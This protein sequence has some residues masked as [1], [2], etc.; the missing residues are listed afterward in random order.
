[1]V[2]EG[3]LDGFVGIFFGGNDHEEV[4]FMAKDGGGDGG[5]G[6]KFGE[7]FSAPVG[8]EGYFFGEGVMWEGYGLDGVFGFLLGVFAFKDDEEDFWVFLGEGLPG[9]V[10][11]ELE[12]MGVGVRG[13]LAWDF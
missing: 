8:G 1:M 6:G 9:E 2:L 13:V 10:G 7:L 5:D 3:E 11:G 12:D 4:S